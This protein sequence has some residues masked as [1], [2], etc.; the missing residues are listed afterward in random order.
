MALVLGLTVVSCG[1]TETD[2]TTESS[3][4]DGTQAVESGGSETDSTTQKP[5]SEAD[6]STVGTTVGG[7]YPIDVGLQPL[8]DLAIADLANRTGSDPGQILVLNAYLVTWPDSSF[9]CPEPD[10]AYLP[11]VFD[12]SVIE[13]GF[14][15]MVYRYHT[16]GDIYEPFLCEEPSG[17]EKAVGQSAGGPAISEGGSAVSDEDGP[18]DG[19]PL[20]LDQ[21]I[22]KYPDETVPPP[23][24]DD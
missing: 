8:I 14:E 23:G 22:D 15:S 3:G 1:D 11:G 5:G 18:L 6:A 24:Y 16:G 7:T 2:A 19:T 21:P 20:E 17:G 10:M 9:G 4:N 13:L 12:G